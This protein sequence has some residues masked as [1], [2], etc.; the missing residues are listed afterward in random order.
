MEEVIKEYGKVAVAAV[1]TGI[2]V[3]VI[4]AFVYEAGPL[5][6]MILNVVNAAS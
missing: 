4:M 3:G 6:N 1:V 5:H 2:L